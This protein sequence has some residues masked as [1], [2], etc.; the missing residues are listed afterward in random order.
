MVWSG[1]TIFHLMGG[2]G[3]GSG[4]NPNLRGV[5]GVGGRQNL[6]FGKFMMPKKYND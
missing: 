4:W 2:L 5:W 1:S 6:C 3:W